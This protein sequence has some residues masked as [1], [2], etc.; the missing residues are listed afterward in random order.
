[1]EA[2]FCLKLKETTVLQEKNCLLWWP[3]LPTFVHT[4]W[5]TDSNS[6]LH[7]HGPLKWLYCMKDPE[8]QVTRWL[9]KLQKFDFKVIHRRG[10]R[11]VNTDALS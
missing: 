7:D 8:A 4:F 11:H 1:M 9:E 2:V 10:S 3:S 5:D 6:V